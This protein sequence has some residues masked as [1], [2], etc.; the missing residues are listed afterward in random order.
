M[1]QKKRV[2][3]ERNFYNSLKHIHQHI[4]SEAINRIQFGL[5]IDGNNSERERSTRTIS[6]NKYILQWKG[7]LRCVSVLHV[8]TMVSFITS[9]LFVLDA[10]Q[11][12]S[13]L[14]HRIKW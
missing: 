10:M 5:Q 7:K 8:Q 13:Q 11:M 9:K 4:F 12:H 3:D 1:Q 2:R 14:T 6:S